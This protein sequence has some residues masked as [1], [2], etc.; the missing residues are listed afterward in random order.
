MDSEP[1]FVYVQVSLNSVPVTCA[2]L[3][4][5]L[6]CKQIFEGLLADKTISSRVSPLSDTVHTVLT[7]EQALH[8]AR[9]QGRLLLSSANA[10]VRSANA[11]VLSETP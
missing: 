3:F 10:S 7:L 1:F 4:T 5:A 9:R 11:V 6:S 2:E 8:S